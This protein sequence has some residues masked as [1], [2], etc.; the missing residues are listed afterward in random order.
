MELTFVNESPGRR[1][2]TWF[3]YY[4]LDPTN[5]NKQSRLADITGRLV[6]NAPSDTPTKALPIPVPSRPFKFPMLNAA[7]MYISSGGP[8][9]L[10]VDAAGNPIPPSA[11]T[12]EDPN[13]N[14]PWDFFEI[15]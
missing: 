14:T 13:Y 5:N 12:P 10:T 8:L 6:P 3:V 7:R 15:T 9:L 2:D 11:A 4:G 1:R